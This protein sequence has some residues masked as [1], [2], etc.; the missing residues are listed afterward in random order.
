MKLGS[1]ELHRL[2]KR[3]DVNRW[4]VDKNAHSF[5]FFRKLPANLCGFVFGDVTGAFRVE[6]EPQEIGAGFR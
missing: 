1:I 3:G 4:G 5:D 2:A 6:I